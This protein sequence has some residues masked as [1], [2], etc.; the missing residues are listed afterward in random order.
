[1][2]ALELLQA[3][4][5]AVQQA[6]AAEQVRADAHARLQAVTNEAQ[7]VFE[8]AV[9]KAKA[10]YDA[11]AAAHRDALAAGERL[12]AQMQDALGLAFQSDSRVRQSR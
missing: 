10:E 6:K 9:G 11:A 1:M 3:T 4:M 2:D 7:A 5:N 8:A 12:K